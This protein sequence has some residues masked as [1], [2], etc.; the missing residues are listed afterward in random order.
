MC[1]VFLKENTWFRTKRDTGMFWFKYEGN[2]GSGWGG[3]GVSEGWMPHIQPHMHPLGPKKGSHHFCAAGAEINN[4][5][6]VCRQHD[7][8]VRLTSRPGQNTPS[9]S[10]CLI[11]HGTVYY[12]KVWPTS[13]EK[14]I[15]EG[16]VSP[17]FCVNITDLIFWK[18]TYC[19]DFAP[20][21]H[22][23]SF[24]FILLTP[25]SQTPL[26]YDT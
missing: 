20:I 14:I 8:P 10:R 6:I 18:A 12:C 22:I 5:D 11:V 21:F 23:E 15:F 3:G 19:F 1:Y 4:R 9:S 16:I 26:S 2:S 24:D 25:N 13:K 17:A 7:P